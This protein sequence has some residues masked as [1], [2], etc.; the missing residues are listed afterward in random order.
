MPMM[1]TTCKWG[2]ITGFKPEYGGCVI[3]CSKPDTTFKCEKHC[4]EEKDKV[5]V[6]KPDRYAV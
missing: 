6:N 5:L 1:C 2:V 4:Y 3:G